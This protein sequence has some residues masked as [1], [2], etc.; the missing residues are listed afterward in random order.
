MKDLKKDKVLTDVGLKKKA[1]IDQEAAFSAIFFI[2]LVE[3]KCERFFFKE[4]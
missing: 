4:K 2:C 3:I 1:Y